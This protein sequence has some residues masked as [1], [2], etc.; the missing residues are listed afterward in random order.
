MRPMIG[1]RRR[2]AP[3]CQRCGRVVPLRRRATS[4]YCTDQCARDQQ[5]DDEASAAS[6][7]AAQAPCENCG[8]HPHDGSPCETCDCDLTAPSC[9]C[10]VMCHAVDCPLGGP[11]DSRPTYDP[12]TLRT[13]ERIPAPQVA[14]AHNERV[15]RHPNGHLMIEETLAYVPPQ[16]EQDAALASLAKARPYLPDHIDGE[17]DNALANV[18]K[19]FAALRRAGAA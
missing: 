12:T 4:D 18:R 10:P 15:V 11:L 7:R 5:R 9:D 6:E 2:T 19:M 3:R 8:C 14:L 13:I 17:Y 16:A 1:K